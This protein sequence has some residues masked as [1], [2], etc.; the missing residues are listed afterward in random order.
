MHVLYIGK[1]V[2]LTEQCLAADPE[3]RPSAQPQATGTRPRHSGAQRTTE[4]QQLRH[5]SH[6][7]SPLHSYNSHV[8]SAAGTFETRCREPGIIRKFFNFNLTS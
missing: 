8:L 7:T 2:E 5:L 3:P 4:E 1:A 6:H